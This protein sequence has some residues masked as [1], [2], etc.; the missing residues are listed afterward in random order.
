MASA[1]RF[2]VPDNSNTPKRRELVSN[3]LQS[4]SGEP[5]CP[6]LLFDEMPGWFQHDNNEWMIRGY[7]PISNSVHTSFR[8]WCF[9]HNETVNICS[10]LI[11]AVVF[12]LGEWYLLRYLAGRYN[13]LT[14]TN[15]AVFSFFMIA[16]TIYYASSALCH[17]LMSHSHIVDRICHRLDML[18]IGI[19]IVGDI[20][21]EV[22]ILFWCE[23][24]IRNV[25][26][27]MVSRSYARLFL[28]PKLWSE[29]TDFSSVKRSGSSG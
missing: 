13:K 9:P 1:C 3:V 21:L 16:A 17:T 20:V 29:P 5:E 15:A 12:F 2:P 26:W 28:F 22:Y 8:S 19:F 7:R 25:Y 27:S 11:P 24:K 4:G 23:T 14:T 18:D 10:H 6:Y